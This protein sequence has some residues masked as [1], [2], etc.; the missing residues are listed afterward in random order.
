[1][2]PLYLPKKFLQ[3]G[4]ECV[5]QFNDSMQQGMQAQGQS[6]KNKKTFII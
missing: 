3:F 6:L 2:P 5:T 1:M 4:Q